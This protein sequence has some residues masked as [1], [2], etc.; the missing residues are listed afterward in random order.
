MSRVVAPAQPQVYV[1]GP[2]R[3][4]LVE[5]ARRKVT[6]ALEHAPR[7]VLFVKLNLGR[8]GAAG[9][10]RPY[11]VAVHADVSG[12]DIHVSAAAPTFTEAVDLAQ[13]KLN[14]RLSRADRWR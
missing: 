13:R 5:Y 1:H 12:V 10:P 9:T 2:I 8:A 6:A 4:G 3:P 14:A 11:T 7:P